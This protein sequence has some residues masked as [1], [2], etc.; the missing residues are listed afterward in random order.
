MVMG[1]DGEVEKKRTLPI[2]QQESVDTLAT[3]NKLWAV[4]L[5]QRQYLQDAIPRT[6]ESLKKTHGGLTA[7]PGE[8]EKDSEFVS[9]R[10]K[11]HLC[12][13][14]A[15]E[16]SAKVSEY[17]ITQAIKQD[18]APKIAIESTIASLRGYF[19]GELHAIATE[20]L[21]A[22]LKDEPLIF[23]RQEPSHL[24][25]S[26][27]KTS[28][29]VTWDRVENYFKA[30]GVPDPTVKLIKLTYGQ[31]LESFMRGYK[32]VM[33]KAERVDNRGK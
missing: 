17:L 3:A 21:E 6:E 23:L 11:A 22:T 2:T 27:A 1:G 24:V 26:I 28:M 19:A 7:E 18:Y 29:Q 10:G 4:V 30:I 20:G 12:I 8:L 31:L 14:A 15:A 9:L 5:S 16:S 33:A 25:A 13:R 32:A